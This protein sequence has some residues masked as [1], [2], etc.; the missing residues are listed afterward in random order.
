MAPKGF[1]PV[2][3][4]RLQEAVSRLVD[5]LD[6]V[7]IVLFGSYACGEPDE[8]S[9][10]DLLVVMETTERPAARIAKVSRLLSPRPFP[11]DIIVRTPEE[12][13]RDCRRTDPF[14]RE[15]VERG[16]VLYERF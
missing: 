13:D 10:V 14:M 1:P 3:E 15:L 12:V 9:D 7:R 5:V 11:V 8:D 16:R 4:E 6:P 2:T